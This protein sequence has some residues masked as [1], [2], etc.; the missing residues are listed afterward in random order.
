MHDQ[1]MILLLFDFSLQ[2]VNNNG[3]HGFF[4]GRSLFDFL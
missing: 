4:E 3:R 2:T 1:M